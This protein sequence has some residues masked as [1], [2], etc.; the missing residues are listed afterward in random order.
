VL[1]F[2]Q[3]K[4]VDLVSREVQTDEFSRVSS[5]RHS[6]NSNA[7]LKYS[8][9]VKNSLDSLYAVELQGLQMSIQL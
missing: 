6:T 9:S 3:F 2:Q 4:A 8:S 5:G 1:G 7:R